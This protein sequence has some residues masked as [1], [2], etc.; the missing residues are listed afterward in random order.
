M[1]RESAGFKAIPASVS[2]VQMNMQHLYWEMFTLETVLCWFH[3]FFIIS[4]HSQQDAESRFFTVKRWSHWP[5]KKE[6]TFNSVPKR[7]SYTRDA[8]KSK[9]L[10]FTSE[11]AW[12]SFW[13]LFPP[14][15]FLCMCGSGESLR[16]KFM[17]WR[18]HPEHPKPYRRGVAEGGVGDPGLHHLRSHT[19]ER[20]SRTR[21][22]R[23]SRHEW[24]AEP[25]WGVWQS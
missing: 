15:W 24:W 13:S 16:G 4:F 6:K 9:K 8:P 22:I 19:G 18:S 12:C 1:E 20:L 5:I 23:E 11:S 21:H 17:P 2:L 14:V 3:V 25:H 7:T 10:W